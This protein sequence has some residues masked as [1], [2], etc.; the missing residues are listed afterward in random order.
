MNKDSIME[1]IHQ[2]AI[3]LA[4]TTDKEKIINLINRINFFKNKLINTTKKKYS[5]NELDLVGRY[6]T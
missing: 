4:K 5:Y 6:G 1:E 3:K 2:L